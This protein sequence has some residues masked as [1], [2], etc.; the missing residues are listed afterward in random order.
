V[1]IEEKSKQKKKR[2]DLPDRFQSIAEAGAFWNS[3]DSTEYEDLIEEVEFDVDI[4]HRVYLVPVAAGIIEQIRQKAE[5]QGVSTE[6]LVNLL[7][8][9]HVG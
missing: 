3:H 2:N 5:S 1:N 7:L 6:T 4:K 9:E 8:Q